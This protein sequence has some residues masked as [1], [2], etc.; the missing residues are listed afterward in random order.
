[1]QI[2]RNIVTHPSIKI[3]ILCKPGSQLFIPDWL[4]RHNQE[5]DGDQE[6]PGMYIAVNVIGSCKDIP[7]S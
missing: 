7:D 2:A 5:T 1:M 6:I 3:Q 4:S